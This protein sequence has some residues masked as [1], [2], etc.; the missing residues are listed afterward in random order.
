[1]A[2]PNAPDLTTLPPPPAP[3]GDLRPADGPRRGGARWWVVLPALALIVGGLALTFVVAT[4]RPS[5]RMCTLAGA[6]GM[7]TADSP[8]AAFDAWWAQDSDL[9]PGVEPDDF[10]RDGDAWYLDTG[11]GTSVQVSV[12]GPLDLEPV[13]DGDWA[14]T[15]VNRCTTFSA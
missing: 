4:N 7:P 15:G 9:Y 1:M 13:G 14:V 10:D 5:S 11:G 2:E 3:P 8:E 12:G 6:I